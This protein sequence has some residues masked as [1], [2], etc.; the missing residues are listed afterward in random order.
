MKIFHP[1][2]TFV[3]IDAEFTP[4]DPSPSGLVSLALHSERGTSYVVNSETDGESF[5]SVEF[6][7]NHIWSKLPLSAD[8]TLNLDHPDVM[9]YAAIEQSANAYFYELTEGEDYRKHV[10]LIAD[11]G[12]QDVQRLHDLFGNDWQG[13]MPKWIPRFL[14]QDLATLKDLAGVE[15]GALSL[16]GGELLPVNSPEKAHHALRDAEYDRVLHEF[17]MEHSRAVRVASGVERLSS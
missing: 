9:P 2:F 15:E 10:G 12:T 16:P 11:H 5:C 7:R 3:Y 6:R 8:G 13:V 17:L 4:D 1:S 14:F